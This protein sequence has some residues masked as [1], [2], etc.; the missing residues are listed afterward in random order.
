MEFLD[1]L[2]SWH[3]LIFGMVML[4]LEMV[5]PGAAFLWIG[6]GAMT[7]G[8]VMLIVT[9]PPALQLTLFALASVASA[10]AW[11]AWSAKNPKTTSHPTLNQRGQTFVGRR[12]TLKNPIVN[13]VGKIVADD[14]TWKVRGP[15][16]PAGT[17]VTVVSVEGTVLMVEQTGGSA[18]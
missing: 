5:A 8:V 7:V 11:K 18:A 10:F 17:N 15:D 3:W 2:V 12:F 1:S 14:S 13:G 6:L 9:L 16:L 4:I